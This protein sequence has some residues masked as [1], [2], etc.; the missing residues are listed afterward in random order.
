VIQGDTPLKL[1]DGLGFIVELEEAFGIAEVE[2]RAFWA[3]SDALIEFLQRELVVFGVEESDTS[4]AVDR[5]DT[6]V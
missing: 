3:V 4:D 5:G 6:E 2:L 1:L